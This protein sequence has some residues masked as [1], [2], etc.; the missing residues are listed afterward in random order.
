VVDLEKPVMRSLY[1]SP[2]TDTVDIWLDSPVSESYSE[3]LTENL[4]GKHNA[5]GETIGFEIIS[6]DKLDAEDMKKMPA[7]A[8]AVLKESASRLSVVSR[9][10]K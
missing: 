4:V 8:R 2:D 3:P 1:Y 7:K 9:A 6:L 10:Q 5:G